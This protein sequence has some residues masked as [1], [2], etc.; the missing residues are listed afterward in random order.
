MQLNRTKCCLPSSAYKVTDKRKAVALSGFKLATPDNEAN[1]FL[2]HSYD[3]Q[4]TLK[5]RDTLPA[6]RKAKFR[7]GCSRKHLTTTERKVCIRFKHITSL[8]DSKRCTNETKV[9]PGSISLSWLPACLITAVK[10]RMSVG[11]RGWGGGGSLS[12]S[13][14]HIPHL[15]TAEDAPVTAHLITA[16]LGLQPSGRTSTPKIKMNFLATQS[17][18]GKKL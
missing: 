17:Q 14:P 7:L 8:L 15:S 16:P 1:A 5:C 10:E 13:P 12:D 11:M 18:R 3:F 4:G 6:C 9:S 2:H